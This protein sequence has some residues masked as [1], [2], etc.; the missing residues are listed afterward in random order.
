MDNQLQQTIAERRINNSMKRVLKQFPQYKLVSSI[1]EGDVALIFDKEDPEHFMVLH[2]DDE[3]KK[4]IKNNTVPQ[5]VIFFLKLKNRRNSKQ[6]V[7]SD[8]FNKRFVK[9]K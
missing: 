2:N 8:I 1:D 4:N 7:L 5:I 3:A 9:Q 6:Q